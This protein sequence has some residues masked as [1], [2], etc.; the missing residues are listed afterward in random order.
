MFGFASASHH[1]FTDLGIYIDSM[2]LDLDPKKDVD[3]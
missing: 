1:P 3:I 2:N